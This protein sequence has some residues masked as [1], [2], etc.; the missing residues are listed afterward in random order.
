LNSCRESAQAAFKVKN[1]SDIRH[2]YLLSCLS[3]EHH[4]VTVLGIG[5]IR[6]VM[7]FDKFDGKNIGRKGGS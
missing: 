5:K 6:L 4:Y 3:P 7:W 2:S 1:Y